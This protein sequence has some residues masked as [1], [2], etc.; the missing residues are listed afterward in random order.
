M[1]PLHLP[2]IY[3]IGTRTLRGPLFFAEPEEVETRKDFRWNGIVPLQSVYDREEF[4]Y[5]RRNSLGYNYLENHHH[6]ENHQLYHDFMKR[7]S[8]LRR[9]FDHKLCGFVAS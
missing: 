6:P 2:S 7:I 5:I 1:S 4:L 9:I 8:H 3:L